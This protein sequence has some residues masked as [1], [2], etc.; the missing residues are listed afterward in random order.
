[1]LLECEEDDGVTYRVFEAGVEPE[2]EEDVDR[3]QPGP[4][5]GLVPLASR[6]SLDIDP[7]KEWEALLCEAW[8]ALHRLF[9][10]ANLNGVDWHAKL[11]VGKV[12][13]GVKDAE[14]EEKERI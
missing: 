11:K 14:E 13:V 7:I 5:S 1:M 8:S 4:E 9:W 3:S 10:D 2:D 12:G 6:I